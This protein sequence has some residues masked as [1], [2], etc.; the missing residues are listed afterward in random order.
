[1]K[2]INMRDARRV[3]GEQKGQPPAAVVVVDRGFVPEGDDQEY[4]QELLRVQNENVARGQTVRQRLRENMYR[5]DT[6]DD[7]HRAS[8]EDA[9]KALNMWFRRSRPGYGGS[10]RVQEFGNRQL[11]A[12]RILHEVQTCQYPGGSVKAEAM[13]LD[14]SRGVQGEVTTLPQFLGA[15]YTGEPFVFSTPLAAAV[16][17]RFVASH[18]MRVPAAIP[19]YYDPAFLQVTREY[20]HD[21]GDGE[22][23]VDARFFA[24]VQGVSK[25]YTEV[26]MI[27]TSATDWMGQQQV[28]VRAY[29]LE[30]VQ[31]EPT[32]WERTRK[33][34][35]AARS[36]L[37]GDK[38]RDI[39][40]EK[41]V[42]FVERAGG[43]WRDSERPDT[44]SLR[45]HPYDV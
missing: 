28:E 25:P 5:V 17:A 3:P 2:R 31:Y 24:L 11:A 45:P 32:L 21:D 38:S 9:E 19:D 1:M 20:D 37:Q 27:E 8:R 12:G 15:R 16:M 43:D 30:E 22:F 4:L 6:S 35:R 41:E 39:K 44:C 29:N 33:A 13:L 34:M 23:Q 14:F 40:R 26:M 18:P 7:F 42:R 10:A 36:R